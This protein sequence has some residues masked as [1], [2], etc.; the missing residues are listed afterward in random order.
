M[1]FSVFTVS[2]PDLTPVELVDTLKECGYNGVEWR[3]AKVPQDAKNEAPT[4]WKNNLCTID[5]DITD[6]ELDSLRELTQIKSLE[7]SAILPY[8]IVGDLKGTENIM[9]IAKKLGAGKIRLGQAWYD[10]SVNYNDLFDKAIKY[11]HA[12]QEMS[13]S[14]GIKGLVE[15]HHLTINPSASM[16]HRLVSGF[17]P[18]HIGIM[19]DPGNLVYEGYE[20]YRKGLELISPYLSHVHVKNVNWIKMEQPEDGTAWASLPDGAVDW[21]QVLIDLK[22]VGYDGYLGFED[23]SQSKPT[24]ELLQFNINYIRSLLAKI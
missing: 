2:T 13:Q 6:K 21:K 4:S 16:A 20:N 12:V 8:L 9:R 15:T 17:N 19:Y 5:P 14:Y 11:L 22:S 24:R 18:D 23:F 3:V 10:R 7:V 1:K